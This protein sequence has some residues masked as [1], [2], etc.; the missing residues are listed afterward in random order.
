ML[1]AGVY[2]PLTVEWQHGGGANYELQLMWTLPVSGGPAVTQL[3]PN[4]NT[5][6][7]SN[8]VTS[9]INYAFWNGTSGQWYP[10]GPGVV[11]PS[12]S[13]QV[14]SKGSV[15]P[16]VCTGFTYSSTAT[17]IT[18]SW[19][20]STALYRSD[21][22]I[23]VIGAGSQTITGLLQGNTYY[24]YPVYNE[25]TS[26]LTFLTSAAA[27][28]S[29]LSGVTLNGTTGY[30]T[31]DT[32]RSQPNSFSVELWVNTTATAVPLIQLSAPDVLG[33]TGNLSFVLAYTVGSGL[34]AQALL[35]TSG[36]ATI[37]TTVTPTLYDG[38]WHH[39]V[40]TWNNSIQTCKVYLDGTLLTNNTAPAPNALASLTNMYWHIGAVGGKAGWGFTSN[41]FGAATL[42]N[43]VFYA[44]VISDAQILENYQ[45]MINLGVAAY[46]G[47]IAALTPLNWWK[48]NETA[49]T[50]AADS[51]SAGDGGTYRGGFVLNASTSLS[52]AI[53][54]PAC[55]FNE[56]TYLM[57]QA[58]TLQAVVPMSAGAISAVPATSG[59]G[60]GGGSGSGCFTAAVPIKTINGYVELGSLPEKFELMNESGR[61]WAELIVHEDYAGWMLVLE[62]SRL[63]TMDHVMK[64]GRDW[65]PAS[66]KYAML[67]RKLFRGTVYN[68]H[69]I[70]DNP[71]DQHFILWN[72][73]VAHNVKTQL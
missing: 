48:L 31:A 32:A 59:S 37:L 38:I 69:V 23:T 3:I 22:T 35:S 27:S 47:V 52:P 5:S 12:S 50:S 6:T 29:S 57:A 66:S 46:D 70:T 4:A 41:T 58:S 61:H 11:D 10:T 34:F 13:V 49:G 45:T 9:N 28:W 8:S 25:L 2:Y 54:T 68:V 20:A 62:G 30:V 7:A 14:L 39:I 1:T 24:F 64:H 60:S 16:T 67:E 56:K 44:S 15:T 72:G 55:A 36:V 42:S 71:D 19:P 53:G 26:T 18:W 40:M 43:V 33:T 63:V 51:G 73:D 21:G 65:I 17:T